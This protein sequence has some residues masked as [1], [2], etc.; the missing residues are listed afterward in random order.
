MNR[1]VDAFKNTLRNIQRVDSIANYL[2][3]LGDPSVDSGASG[4]P[5]LMSRL[6]LHELDYLYLQNDLAG[7]I[8]DEIVEDALRNGFTVNVTD[9]TDPDVGREIERLRAIVK[10]GRAAKWGRLY[11]AGYVLMVLDDGLDP[12]A[13]VEPERVKRVI[14][15][16][17][18]DIWEVVPVRWQ[19]DVTQPRFGEPDLYQVAPQSQGGMSAG[20]SVTTVHA[21]RL[22]KF[23]GVALPRHLRA[24]NGGH[25][26]SVLQRPWDA[27]RRFCEAE[28]GMAR[29][30]QSFERATISYAGLSSVLAKPE[31]EELVAQRMQ[32]LSRSISMINA[33]LLD[34]DAG[35]Q[36][37]RSSSSVAGLPEMRDRFAESVAKAARMPQTI[38]FGTAP[39]GLNT[40]GESGIQAWHKR[41]HAYQEKV[42]QP[43]LERLVGLLLPPGLDIGDWDIAWNP[44]DEPSELE[45][46]ELRKV[47]AEIDAIYLDRGVRSPDQVA[48]SRDGEA[49]WSMETEAPEEDAGY[50][51]MME[52]LSK[53]SADD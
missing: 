6:E 18:L 25:D 11:G 3:G 16:V 24:Q 17:D 42:L 29:I 21:S 23:G 31:G 5:T 26:D 41:V 7:I 47:V 38:L 4:R 43:E 35:E 45:Q 1:V 15:L 33:V 20:Q 19:N 30:V 32:M 28:N 14:E 50:S 37:E 44:L 2:S 9:G 51:A 13:P 46:A 39:A 49:G 34:A 52:S 36:Y 22:L 27:I 53:M 40:D 8:V 12:A 48:R 10:L